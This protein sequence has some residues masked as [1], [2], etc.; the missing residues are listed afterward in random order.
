MRRGRLYFR[1]FRQKPCPGTQALLAREGDA[2]PRSGRE[3]GDGTRT[4]LRDCSGRHPVRKHS[5]PFRQDFASRSAGKGLHLCFPACFFVAESAFDFF[6]AGFA[7]V[8]AG[9][10]AGE[11]AFAGAWSSA[12]FVAG[13]AFETGGIETRTGFSPTDSTTAIVAS[14][15]AETIRYVSS[16]VDFDPSLNVSP[17]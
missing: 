6:A 14:G 11:A 3:I 7:A 10:F 15:S 8:F 16:P 12:G 13:R 17:T 1:F 5:Q 9:V 2:T 4:G